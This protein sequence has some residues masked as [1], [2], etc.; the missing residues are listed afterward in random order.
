MRVVLPRTGPGVDAPP[1]L[2]AV[3]LFDLLVAAALVV[4]GTVAGLTGRLSPPAWAPWA[5]AAFGAL[6]LVTDVAA[7]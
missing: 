7:R 4:A 6:L 2:K 5:L 3:L 1:F